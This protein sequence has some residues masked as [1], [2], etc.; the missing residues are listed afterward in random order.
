MANWQWSISYH[1]CME[2]T[3]VERKEQRRAIKF[4]SFS[5]L[6]FNGSDPTHMINSYWIWT[7]CSIALSMDGWLAKKKKKLHWLN[8]LNPWLQLSLVLFVSHLF[9]SLKWF[10]QSGSMKVNG[11]ICVSKDTVVLIVLEEE[12][13]VLRH[14]RVTT[15]NLV[16]ES[17]SI[18]STTGNL[19]W[20]SNWCRT[21]EHK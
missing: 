5:S 9:S 19:E 6:V 15:D 2:K 14:L 20:A 12:Y 1:L 11:T 10:Y 21:M 8:D 7:I 17:E 13:Q 18:C 4:T 16:K 3:G